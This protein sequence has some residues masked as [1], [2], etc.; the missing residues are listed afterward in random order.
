MKILTINLTPVLL[1][2]DMRPLWTCLLVVLEQLSRSPVPFEPFT[3]VN[4]L[5]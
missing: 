2:Q 3:S 4:H 5:V 1:K